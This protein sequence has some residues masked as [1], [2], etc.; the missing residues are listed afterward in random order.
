MEKNHSE[1][2]GIARE[3]RQQPRINAVNPGFIISVY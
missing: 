3:K 2:V 1:E